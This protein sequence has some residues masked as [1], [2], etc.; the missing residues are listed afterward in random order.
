MNLNHYET[1]ELEVIELRANTDIITASPGI[2][3]LDPDPLP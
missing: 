2:P 3:T 1:P